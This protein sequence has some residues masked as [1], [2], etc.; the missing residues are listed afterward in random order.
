M[1]HYIIRSGPV[2]AVLGLVFN[3]LY[4]NSKYVWWSVRLILFFAF[5]TLYVILPRRSPILGLL[6]C[7]IGQDILLFDHER[8]ILV[9]LSIWLSDN[10]GSHIAIGH[11]YCSLHIMSHICWSR[12]LI[13][14]YCWILF[15]K[16]ATYTSNPHGPV[17]SEFNISCYM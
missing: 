17:V 3:R 11:I 9:G 12:R 2:G 5:N 10:L 8:V 13:V 4:K 14:C 6:S 15:L 1:W 7:A 16:E